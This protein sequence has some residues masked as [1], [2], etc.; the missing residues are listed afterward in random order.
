MKGS[1]VAELQNMAEKIY[2]ITRQ[3]CIELDVLWVPREVIYYADYLS[4]LVDHDDW[5]ISQKLFG[6]LLFG[7]IYTTKIDSYYGILEFH[8]QF[9]WS[10]G[11]VF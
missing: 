6:Y 8:S 9:V 1:P 3:N 2:H 4:K 7:Q 5:C 11:W 10:L